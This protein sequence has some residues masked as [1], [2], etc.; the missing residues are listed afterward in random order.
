MD[1]IEKAIAF[2][3]E[4]HEGQVRKYTGLPYIIHPLAVASKV[5][6]VTDDKNMYCAA[7]LH[8]VVEDTKFSLDDIKYSFGADIEE[9][10]FW[11]TD[12]SQPK[13]G[14]RSVRKSIDREHIG[15][16]PKEA[17]TIK[18][19]DLIHNT[20]S[21]VKHDERFAKVYMQE[22]R[23][24]LDVLQE[25][26][27]ELHKQ[28]SHIVFEYEIK[29]ASERIRMSQQAMASEHFFKVPH[30]PR[31]FFAGRGFNFPEEAYR[32]AGI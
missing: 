26:N 14:K 25:G 24:L 17:K 19:A 3:T 2:A 21:I 32:I 10:V 7:I 13:H 27:E 29:Q 11:L 23:L 15:R 22:K 9:L 12:I 20:Q 16:A 18:L 1:I 8:D 4:A 28:A 31:E 30:R 6:E 5:A